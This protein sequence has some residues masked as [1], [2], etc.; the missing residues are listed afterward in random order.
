MAD[1]MATVEE[2][3]NW[4][5]FN[6]DSKKLGQFTSDFIMNFYPSYSVN[7]E[8]AVKSPQ[9]NSLE[10]LN[11][12]TFY[13]VCECSIYD[14]EDKF[15]FFAEKMKK[16][17]TT[18][19]SIKQEVCYGI[20]SNAGKTSLVLGVAPN[21]NDETIRAIIEGLLPGAKLEKYADR[22]SNEKNGKGLN[23]KDK[24]RY[25]GCICGVPSLKIDGEYQKKD[26]SSLMRSL[27]GQNY[28]IMVLC[29]PVDEY[30]IQEKINQAIKIQDEC[31]AISK[32][33]VS[34]Q[35][36]K[37][38][39][40]THTE[41]FNESNGE[42]EN[43][44][45]GVNASGAIPFAAA[46]AAIGSIIPGVGTAIGAIGGGLIGLVVGQ[47]LNVNSNKSKG[48]TYSISQGYSNAVTNT[49]SSSESISGDIQNGFAIELMNMAESMTER[50]KIGRSI[51][52]WESVVTY[53]SDSKITSDIIQ[54]SLYS[55]IASGI[56]EVL[57]PVVFSYKDSCE[58]GNLPINK[59]HNQQ[60]MIPKRFFD[61]DCQSPL[62]SLVTSEEIC[63]ICTIP[64]DNTV[65]FEIKESKSYALN[66][67]SQPDDNVLGYVCEYD[68]P[69]TNVPFGL[70]EYDLNKHTFVC[71]ITGSGKTNTVKKILEMVDKPFLVIEPAKKEYRNIK[72]EVDVYT[73]GRPEINCMKLN[74]FYILPGISPQQHIDLLKDL[75]SAS[76]AFYGPMPYILEKCLYNIYI[77]KG[78]NLTLGFHPS[79]INTK[80]LQG[81]FD[82][83]KL[84]TLY[85]IESHKYLFPTMQDLKD[86][87][88]Y[89]I[90][91]EMTY[92][93][94]VKGNIRGAIK[95]RIDSLSVGS[96]GF[97]FNT[98]D[99]VDFNSLLGKNSV[100][101]FEGLADDADKAFALGLIIIYV[102][103]YRQ[104]EKEVGESKGLKHLLVIEEAH[105]LL[106]NVS[107]ENNDELGNPKGKAVEHFTNLLAEMRSYG[108]GV[109]VAEQIP[110]K[111][112]P[113]VIKNSSNKIIH[114]IIA[115]D[116]QEAVA[117][118]IGVYPEDAIYLGNSK[119]GYALCHKEGMVQ[120]VIVKI[121][122]VDAN[123]VLDINLYNKDIENKMFSINRSIIN[124]QMSKEISVW[125]VKTLVSL[126]YNP[127]N[128]TVYKGLEF[129]CEKIS[130]RASLIAVTMIP[131]I[132]KRECV[133]S[134]ISE[135]IVSLMMSGVFSSHRLPDDDFVS[136]LHK[137]VLTPTKDK[138]TNLQ[139]EFEKYY[140]KKPANK[141]IQTIAGLVSEEYASDFDITELVKDFT[142]LKN[143]QLSEEVKAYLGEKVSSCQ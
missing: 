15:S 66:C 5:I 73:L 79:L 109:I 93:G 110:C 34:L 97:M 70:S 41:T 102:N 3:Q 60:L 112:A 44:N 64:T 91:N 125:A 30:H 122:E 99:T 140:D 46:G 137:T 43:K 124:N 48:T 35:K 100:L 106:K 98:N 12:F 130:Y 8:L 87:V 1:E 47:Q 86:E 119:V 69:L 142:L 32:R 96:K 82:E 19:Y 121:D 118:T 84:K 138:L 126:M 141:V 21:S 61:G 92:E 7:N 11:S 80:N 133:L 10:L 120:P 88:D 56:P 128:K 113:D 23:A 134:C 33:T 55:E 38:E 89:Y 81:L 68:R 127:D 131:G 65:G 105:R 63:G 58:G 52:M 17:F 4:V 20:V 53:S 103:E 59:I 36:G 28:T 13:R 57:P 16:L 24:D 9:E 115:K 37:S 14:V 132:K 101:E 74:P 85:A 78:W 31:F 6:E 22:F 54:G 40:N 114:R 90:E 18:A 116:D 45:R 42:N 51:G 39:G 136:L 107:T 111:L 49:I 25:V 26:L 75:F 50:L 108:Q 123:H 2:Q 77:K 76:F 129:A 71:G 94:E 27:N 139:S 72:K 135:N 117:N 29:K 143:S 62:C 83:S 67:T 104:V 95:A